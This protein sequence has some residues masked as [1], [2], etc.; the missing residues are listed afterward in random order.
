MV[1]LNVFAPNKLVT[2]ALALSG[3]VIV[4]TPLTTL[5]LVVAAP[6]IEMPGESVTVL[7]QVVSK[8]ISLGPAFGVAKLSSSNGPTK[9]LIC[10]ID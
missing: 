10:A 6:N 7:L 1:Y 4:A 9:P 2:V 8:V 5:H 3:L